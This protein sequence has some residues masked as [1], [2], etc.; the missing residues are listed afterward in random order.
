MRNLI[1]VRV[2]ELQIDCPVSRVGLLRGVS[3]R[4]TENLRMKRI[5]EDPRG[6]GFGECD[7]ARR[8]GRISAE[9]PPIRAALVSEGSD[10]VTESVEALLAESPACFC[11][12]RRYQPGSAIESRRAVRGEVF[13]PNV[14]VVTLGPLQTTALDAIFASLRSAFSGLSVLAIPVQPESFDVMRALERGAADFLLPPLR[15]CELIPRL[16]RQTLV[17]RPG[18][19]LVQKLKEEIGLKQIIGESPSLLAEIRR[20]PRFAH[21]DATVLISGESGTGKEVFARAIHNLSPRAGGPF[22]PVNCGA[23]PEH[24]VESEIFG[25]KRG[26]FTG[27]SSDHPGLVREAEGGTLFLDEIDGLT[28]QAQVKLLR[29]LQEGEYRAVGS[30][31]IVRANVRVVAAANADFR[32]IVSEGK[33]REDLFYRLNVLTLALPAL[34]DRR[35]DIVLLARH[36]LDRQAA[37]AGQPAKELSLAALNRLLSY[38]WPGNVREL[39]NVLT[40]GAVLSDHPT[41]EPADLALPEDGASTDDG[42]FQ[43]VKARLV[44]R[45]E[46]DFLQ[47]V[48]RS[49][50]GNITHAARAVK[51][52]RRAFWELLRKHG[53]LAGVKRD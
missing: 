34:R 50:Q 14:V 21:C 13:D 20:V 4:D 28:R 38:P 3:L 42:S 27:A 48:L 17:A 11:E 33:F 26:A 18:E 5:E 15:R 7:P 1:R 52:N 22:V 47:T 6:A 25:H 29:F 49:H 12:R 44:Q 23:I 24:L 41:I 30:Q 43:V 16:L 32:Q 45:F 40:R 53:L 2:G 9:N 36:F 31:Q 19:A 35:G 37:L 10:A 39:Q 51:K 46:H 8:S